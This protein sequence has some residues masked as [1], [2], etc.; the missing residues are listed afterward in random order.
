MV[1]GSCSSRGCFAMTDEAIA[2]VYSIAREAFA[3]GQR[4]FQF[5]AYPFHMT[6]ENFARYRGDPNM[7][8]W[9]QLK[10]GSDRFEATGLEPAVGVSGGRYVFGPYR[11]PAKEA[12]AQARRSE[13]EARIAALVAE[14]AASVRI[15]Y[16]DGGQHPSFAAL[17]RR[18]VNVG[19]V[20]RPE[21][22]ALA[23]RET[24][25]APARPKPTM[26][27]SVGPVQLGVPALPRD[28]IP[29]AEAV[30][31]APGVT[32]FGLPGPTPLAEPPLFG[33]RFLTSLDEAAAAQARPETALPGSV[34]IL[35]SALQPA[36][37]EVAAGS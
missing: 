35:T 4:A 27:A 10:E 2:E 6:A 20:S 37:F 29:Q 22:L 8:F 26:V 12:L 31:P 1:L 21:A 32:T 18:G 16:A 33:R 24:I 9:R 15:S 19:E 36:R 30:R 34:R 25:V 5:Q 7:P 23:A 3:G 13:Q 14:G 17:I 28:G 11:D